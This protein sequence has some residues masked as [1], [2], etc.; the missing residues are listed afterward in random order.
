VRDAS[1]RANAAAAARADAAAAA[2]IK[3]AVRERKKAT[4]EEM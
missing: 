4:G 1:L 3:R 2:E